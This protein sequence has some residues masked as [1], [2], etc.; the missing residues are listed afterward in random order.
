M[1]LWQRY[2]GMI[3]DCLCARVLT[4][5]IPRMEFVHDSVF[6]YCRSGL[7]EECC[8]VCIM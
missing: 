2:F 6:L 8:S 4:V 1:G 7:R 3:V 5:P